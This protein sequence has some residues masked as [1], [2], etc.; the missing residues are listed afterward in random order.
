MQAAKNK[1][2]SIITAKLPDELNPEGRDLSSGRFP[3]YAYRG[4]VDDI[5]IFYK[6]MHAGLDAGS[7]LDQ[8][9][10]G[11]ECGALSYLRQC[12]V[13]LK[14]NEVGTKK[15]PKRVASIALT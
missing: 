2:E 10:R 5:I 7:L 3:G 12:T 9:G 15:V 6:G 1:W 8:V 14:L 13:S 4:S 11:L